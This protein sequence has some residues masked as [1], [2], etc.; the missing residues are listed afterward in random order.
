MFNKSDVPNSILDPIQSF[1]V[2]L[3]NVTIDLQ[4]QLNF[5]HVF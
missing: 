5:E 2:D 3:L 1:A 4:M